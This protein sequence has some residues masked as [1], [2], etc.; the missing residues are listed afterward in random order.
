MAFA[1][2]FPAQAELQQTAVGRAGI[3]P[4]VLVL[5]AALFNA[6]LAIVNARVMPLTGNMIILFEVLIVTAGH[7][8]VLSHFQARMV[9]W[10]F[11]ILAF[12]AF[13]LLRII[14]T[15]NAD[16]K[17]FR[18]IFLIITFILLGMTSNTQRSIQMMVVLQATVIAGIALEA[19]CLDCYTDI[20]A[21]K[22]FYMSTR[23][24]GEEEFTNLS[25]DLY[26]S[27]TRPEARFLPFF[28]L[29]RLSSV[30]LEPVSLGNFMI[31]TVAFT[32]AFWTRLSSGLRAFCVGSML[33]M[34]L[35]SDGRL[36]A[37]ASVAIIALS[38]GHRLL[39]RHAALLFVPAVT[40]M[41]LF[42]SY[43]AELK[44]GVDD[45]SGRIAY[46]ADLISN[47]TLNDITGLSDRLLEQS[48]DAGVVYLTITQSLLGLTLLWS[49]I[50][51]SADESS[52]EQ[53]IYK[54]GLLMYL[55]L[56][57]MVSYSFLSI[58][59]AAPIWF[60]FGALLGNEP[61]AKAERAVQRRMRRT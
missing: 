17:Y 59:T 28:D 3:T 50:T 7:I 23:G 54:N 5:A 13:A 48:V 29:H 2:R 25:S 55:A 52:T 61:V 31:A 53:K 38:I 41:A 46:T 51:L 40:G 60:T 43:A 12:A 16:A 42:V 10:Y 58:K 26:V 24:I 22:D 32:A 56:T 44:T 34:L 49:F 11:L 20:F 39:P 33:L 21:V 18:D 36:A 30:F 6:A 37:L 27:A 14:V 19:I 35:A 4:L 47:L 8:Y 15:G 45:L 1:A 9:N 57:M